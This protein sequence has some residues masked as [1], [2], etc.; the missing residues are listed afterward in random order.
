MVF[1]ALTSLVSAAAA[2]G[3]SSAALA[4]AVTEVPQPEQTE[5]A[6][7]EIIVTAQKRAQNIQDVPATINA[8]GSEMIR[9]R[10]ISSLQD[11]QTQVAGLKFD[12]VAGVS[13]ISIRG[14]GTSFTTGAGENSAAV[15]LDGIYISSS[16]AAGIGQMDLGNIEVLR[17]PQGT[18]YG[19]NSTAGVINFI[20]AAPSRDFTAGVT[21]G[22]GNYDDK[23]A[24]AYVS[25][26]LSGNVR[27]RLYVEGQDR[28]GY[29]ENRVTNQDVDDLEQIG[30]RIGIDADLTENWLLEARLTARNE[31]YKGPVFQPYN[32]AALPLPIPGTIVTPR[33][34]NSPVDYDGERKVRLIS[35]KNTFEL[36]DLDL[37]SI[38]G[39]TKTRSHDFFDSLAQGGTDP[40]LA[41]AQIP[42]DTVFDGESFSQE[43]NLKGR[44]GSLEW[45]AGAFYFHDTQTQD[46]TVDLTPFILGAAP[47]LRRR[48]DGKY[49]RDNA[50]VFVDGTLTLSDST[51][52]FAGIRGLYER[53]KNDLLVELRLLDGTL[54]ST[55]CTPSTPR[56]RL[57]DWAATGRAGVQH[58]LSSEAMVYG[59]LSRGYKS[60]GFSSSTC[61]NQF[62]PETV[63]AVEVGAKTRFLDR[64]G[65]LNVSAY[66]YD[67]RDLGIEQ[68]TIFGTSI[69]NAPKSR[70]LG[71]DLDG[72]F[73]INDIWSVDG[74]ATFLKTKYLTFLSSGGAPFG[75]LDGT[76][77]AGRRLNKA[78]GASGTIGTT[79]RFPVRQGSLTLRGEGYF[80][81][82]FRLREY[83]S[84]AL[85]QKGYE[86]F[87]AFLTYKPDDV[88]TFRAFARN[89]TKTDYL[90]GTV[91]ELLGAN[92][93]F[94][95]PRTYGLEIGV[96]LR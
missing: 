68:S 28:D 11:L 77:L 33:V 21:V 95:P 18:L 78:P 51:R 1:R 7:G 38:S 48:A 69:V 64:R 35:L 41:D 53:Q 20:S 46:S 76:S 16:R 60:G 83:N 45:L 74:N 56:Q 25:G 49:V 14:L 3:V 37:V 71:V 36:G 88:W 93:V 57:K 84:P 5:P 17:G 62:K 13:N 87:N 61:R 81:S 80:S 19:K 58:D 23:R 73:E 59:Q 66:Y 86:V 94:N 9:D 89:I 55:D 63:N 92:G 39:Y 50:S 27:A 47:T 85:R 72:R 44:S 82:S 75:D 6:R 2:W 22:Y 31:Y 8:F 65:T 15:H 70:I 34:I 52:V 91:V 40:A 12:P 32:R 67:Y 43:L 79:L 4:Q 24:R 42:I 96:E 90:L 54:L 26:P 10:Q 30:G 29:V